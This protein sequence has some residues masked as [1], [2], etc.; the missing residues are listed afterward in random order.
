MLR[1]ALFLMTNLAIIVVAGITLS[2]L[3]VTTYF[4]A[5]GGLNLTNLLIFAAVF[6]FAGSFISLLLS[7]WMAKRTM[8]VRLIEKPASAKERWL[9]QTVERLCKQSDLPMPEVGIFPSPQINAFATGASKKS[10]LVAVS[11]GLLEQMSEGEAEAVVAHE[12]AHIANGD[13]ITLTLIQGIVNTFVIFFARIIGHF[14]DRVVFRNEGGHGIGF[15]IATIVAEI[16]LAVLASIIV[17]WFSRYRE[18]HADAG[19]ARLVGKEKMI[20]ALERLKSM[21]PEPLSD[22]ML[23]F[24]ISGGEVSKFSAL[25]ASH[26]PLEKR[27]EALRHLKVDGLQSA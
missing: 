26:P 9:V 3:G 2:L 14:V 4:D 16:I 17:M 18:F 24:G 19:S 5:Q 25:F 6:G 1:I 8:G 15:F 10:S 21:H 12:V 13:M 20:A 22:E 27:I 23:A 7:R 11:S